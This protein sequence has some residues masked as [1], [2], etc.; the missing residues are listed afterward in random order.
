MDPT[1]PGPQ[2]PAGSSRL[3]RKQNLTPFYWALVLDNPQLLVLFS[4][5]MCSPVSFPKSGKVR[6][7]AEDLLAARISDGLAKEA[8]IRNLTVGNCFLVTN[9]SD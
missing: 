2:S 1:L 6:H 3:P 4:R 9:V 8:G 5:Q 7:T